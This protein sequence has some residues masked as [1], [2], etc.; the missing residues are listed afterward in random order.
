MVPMS[1][2]VDI[3]A[4]L[5]RIGYDGTLKPTVDTLDALI[6]AHQRSI[7]FENLTPLMGAP[8]VD[9]G[10]DALFDKMVHRARGGYCFEQ[11]GLFLVVLTELGFDA[12]ARGARVVWMRPDGL[13]GPPAA[14]THQLLSVR[15]P[16]VEQRYLVDVGFGGQT[17]TA[18]LTF[19]PGRVQQTRHEPYRLR[20]LGLEWVLETQIGDRWHPLYV[21]ADRP[22]PQIDLE[23][24]SWYV[25][26]Y[27][28]SHF[29]TGLSAAM[30]TDEARWNLG[31]RHLRVHHRDGHTDKTELRNASE[32]LQ[33]LMGTYGLD[34]GGLGDVHQRITEVI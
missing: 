32:V 3:A 25:S 9:L 24:G 5:K 1:H 18:A 22:V 20:A 12:E 29:V 16:G 4:Y 23:V 13:D 19:T 11:N 7:V 26:T 27:P 31:G 28:E 17:P 8:V 15:I 14:Q 2:G 33:V 10:G 34:V 30:V 21:F 6:A